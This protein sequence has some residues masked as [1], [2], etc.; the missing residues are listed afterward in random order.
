MKKNENKNMSP[1]PGVPNELAM[2]IA[3]RKRY[4]RNWPDTILQ[5]T[6]RVR[7]VNQ[8]WAKIM[9][10]IVTT[11]GLRVSYAKEGDMLVV[12]VSDGNKVERYPIT[13]EELNAAQ[14]YIEVLIMDKLEHSELMQ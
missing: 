12:T 7:A 9:I 11:P 10:K 5:L 1:P 8:S 2:Q 14:Q 6:K 4:C 3:I 13:A